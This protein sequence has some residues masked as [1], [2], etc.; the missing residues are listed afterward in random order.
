MSEASG[1]ERRKSVLTDEDI[2]RIKGATHEIFAEQFT[3]WGESIG[4]DVTTPDSRDAIRTDHKFV[5]YLRKGSLWAIGIAA[6]AFI[7]AAAAG[8]VG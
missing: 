6:A 1:G 7:T 2:T 4:Y 5:R 8:L 3:R